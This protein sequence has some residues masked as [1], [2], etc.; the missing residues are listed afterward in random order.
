MPALVEN[1][2]I[3]IARPPLFKITRK[4][5][6]QYIHS[7]KEMDEYLLRLGLSDLILRKEGGSNPY[8]KE[9]TEQ[10]IDL[11]LEVETFISSIERKGVPFRDFIAENRPQYQVSM[12]ETSQFVFSEEELLSLKKENEERQK[13]VHEETLAS[14]PSEEVT[15]E[16]RQFSPKP[17]AFLE[18]F[19]PVKLKSF[20]EKLASFDVKLEQYL[21]AQ[22][23]LFE[24]LEE[25][26]KT[27]PYQ[28]M[29]ELMDAVR[30][31]GRK[32]VEVQRYKGLGEMNADQLW[33]TTMNP[34]TR[35]LVRVS[36]PD[37][38]AADRMFSMLMGEEVEPRR[39]FIEQHA[40]S[41]KNLDI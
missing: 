19:D 3:Y 5:T 15:E 40:L 35:T 16:M 34:V 38:I 32:G 28:T 10:L 6:S 29:R 25:G 23:D 26:G 33:D 30:V 13:R 14:I 22:G 39:I 41:V 4:K 21:I 36:L 24:L 9:R 7:E 8:T 17:I 20:E 11:V 27:T 31:N 18:L 1:N 12:G 2:F 37:A